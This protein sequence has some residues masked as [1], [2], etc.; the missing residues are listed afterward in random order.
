MAAGP[1]AGACDHHV[2]RIARRNASARIV[3]TGCYATREPEALAS[4]PGVVRLVTRSGE[5][6]ES[7]PP[8]IQG[9]LGLCHEAA[10]LA[11]LVA[12]G[13]T[14]SPLLPLDE[15]VAIMETLDEIR[16]LVGVRYPGE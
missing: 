13:A 4:L 6:H 7:E 5:V 9:H 10:H 12:E 1:L 11:Q 15:T 3:V 14:E 16:A 2:R 8:A